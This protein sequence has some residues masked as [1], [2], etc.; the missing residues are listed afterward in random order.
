MYEAR[1]ATSC[2]ACC[3]NSLSKVLELCDMPPGDKYEAKTIDVPT[4]LLSSSIYICEVCG[5]LQMSA[6]ADPN[7]IYGKYLSDQLLRTLN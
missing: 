6:S 1:K 3:S 5:H 7:Y 2:R 4:T